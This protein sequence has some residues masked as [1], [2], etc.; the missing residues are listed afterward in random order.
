MLRC[1]Q[2]TGLQQTAAAAI[3]V[4]GIAKF[5]A[6]GCHIVLQRHLAGMNLRGRL[7]PNRH[8][9]GGTAGGAAVA[10]MIAGS[11]LDREGVEHQFPFVTAGRFDGISI[12]HHMAAVLTHRIA[13][14]SILD[15]NGRIGTSDVHAPTV[16]AFRRPN[17]RLEGEDAAADILGEVV[18]DHLPPGAVILEYQ[19]HIVADIHRHSRSG[20]GLVGIIG[21]PGDANGV[22]LPDA[23]G[24]VI[25]GGA[26]GDVKHLFD[27]RQ[28]G[29]GSAI[30]DSH[31]IV[32]LCP[33]SP[34]HLVLTGIVDLRSGGIL[35]RANPALPVGDADAVPISMGRAHVLPAHPCVA[36]PGGLLTSVMEAFQLMLHGAFIGI[37]HLTIP[38]FGIDEVMVVVFLVF[39][40]AAV[41]T[42]VFNPHSPIPH[43]LPVGIVALVDI[44]LGD[45]AVMVG[46]FLVTL[47]A[48]ANAPDFMA[49]S[50]VDADIVGSVWLEDD[51]SQNA[52]HN[53]HISAPIKMGAP[54]CRNGGL[55]PVP[56]LVGDDAPVIQGGIAGL[57]GYRH[58]Q[59]RRFRTVDRVIGITAVP[60]LG[61][62]VGQNDPRSV[63]VLHLPL[64][65]QNSL[66][67]GGDVE[68]DG[69]VLLVERFSFLGTV[70]GQPGHPA[71]GLLQDQNLGVHIEAAV[72]TDAI[73][74]QI[75]ALV[76]EIGVVIAEPAA[77]PVSAS[78]HLPLRLGR[79]LVGL[80][81]ATEML[82]LHM[83][84]EIPFVE[85]TVT[86]VAALL[87]GQ[88]GA[89]ILAPQLTHIP[90]GL[91]QI[92]TVGAF[93][94][95]LAEV[96]IVI[97]VQDAHPLRA[98]GHVLAAILTQSA[99][100]AGLHLTEGNAAI[101][102][103]MLEPL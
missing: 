85:A 47:T 41:H 95:V 32:I 86:A 87:L 5:A 18:D 1:Q 99:Q 16:I 60:P 67:G 46:L 69:V 94:A 88:H 26:E 4:T 78:I 77:V 64:I 91:T 56:L 52:V 29:A 102:A 9:A 40:R 19:R 51:I 30:A 33:I 84:L 80:I 98:V 96:Q 100:L 82:L 66:P 90:T 57:R 53:R 83:G 12:R 27:L 49:D 65:G 50:F 13:G 55:F 15:A 63:I 79:G 24:L 62:L 48:L 101:R 81:A 93:A 31:Q 43:R 21:V 34:D 25:G 2:G 70:V 22:F 11:L 61:H 28:I 39:L 72:G 20:G 8:T 35:I 3:G 74:V 75:M 23:V 76:T 42:G 73:F 54:Q 6:G 103:Q 14:I 92:D 97:I 37:V 59:I 10:P 71:F 45:L 17:H 89:A 58:G 68:M 7:A 38:G 36:F 44:G